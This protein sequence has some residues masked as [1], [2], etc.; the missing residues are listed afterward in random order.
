MGTARSIRGSMDAKTYAPDRPESDVFVDALREV[1]PYWQFRVPV[2]DDCMPT[3][4]PVSV[5]VEF[6]VRDGKPHVYVTH[7]ASESKEAEP[8]VLKPLHEEKL[9]YP[10]AGIR[11]GLRGVVVF[12]RS[13][14]DAEGGVTH[15]ETEI[16]P[17]RH[18][19]ELQPFTREAEEK[20]A[21]WRYPAA[22][23]VPMRHI[24]HDIW[25]N[26]RD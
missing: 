1:L 6:E 22:A 9:T 19:F 5:R 26:L 12:A 25:F 11:L 3:Q 23:N 10:R 18:Q 14:V 17:R 13:D 24:C 20:L 4:R 16:Y 8:P 15:V 2:G 21:L 7:A